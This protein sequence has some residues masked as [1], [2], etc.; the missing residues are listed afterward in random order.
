MIL[1]SWSLRNYDKNKYKVNHIPKLAK[2][3]LQRDLKIPQDSSEI[4]CCRAPALLLLIWKIWLHHRAPCKNLRKM[5]VNL[6]TFCHCKI[7]PPGEYSTSS[8]FN[9]LFCL[10][11]VPLCHNSTKSWFQPF[12]LGAPP[13]RPAAFAPVEWIFKFKYYSMVKFSMKGPWAIGGV[14]SLRDEGPNIEPSPHY[15]TTV[16]VRCTF[17]NYGLMKSA[18]G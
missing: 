7:L 13:V 2:F 9:T 17:L 1:P 16:L 10:G 14:L 3:N 5:T 6:I 15:A 11:K 12:L 8:R 18:D 4:L